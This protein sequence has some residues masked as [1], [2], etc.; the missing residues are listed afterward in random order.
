MVYDGVWILSD[1]PYIL[2]DLWA[3]AY[4]SILYKR[5]MQWRKKRLFLLKPFVFGSI[6]Q[7][8]T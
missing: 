4:S 2:A 8:N 3:K 1:K 6:R 5:N 7:D